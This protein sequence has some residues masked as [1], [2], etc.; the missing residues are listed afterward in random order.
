MGL[1]KDVSDYYLRLINALNESGKPI[2][3]V[4]IPSG[5][6]ADTG[7]ILGACVKANLTVALGLPKQ[8]FYQGEGPT[9]VGRVE[10]ADIG[11]PQV[12]LG[13]SF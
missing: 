13:T 1:N 3:S 12:I 9:M 10:V 5:L 7:R 11:I 6:D 2:V 8:G 4:D